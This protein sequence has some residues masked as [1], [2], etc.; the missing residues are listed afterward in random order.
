[1]SK[2]SNPFRG[3]TYD[4]VSDTVSSLMRTT[5]KAQTNTTTYAP[6][7][8]KVRG[9][10]NATSVQVTGPTSMS[11]LNS[12]G[13]SLGN[14]SLA[15]ISANAS[16]A[17]TDS[18]GRTIPSTYLADYETKILDG[19]LRS[20]PNLTIDVNN[21][22]RV[23]NRNIAQINL[24]DDSKSSGITGISNMAPL[25]YIL[26]DNALADFSMNI[27]PGL[28]TREVTADDI[29]KA[30][31]KNAA[32]RK[33]LVQQ[34]Q[35]TTP[36]ST[37]SSKPA[38]TNPQ[39]QIKFNSA[40]G[41]DSESVDD[42][43]DEYEEF[44]SFK[45]G[46]VKLHIPPTHVTITQLRTNHSVPMI[47]AASKPVMNPTNRIVIKVNTI[48]SGNDL[49][50]NH[51]KRIISQYIYCPFNLIRSE[52]LFVKLYDEGHDLL[53]GYLDTNYIPVTMDAFT[54]YTIQ[55]HPNTLG[56]SLQF[57]LFNFAPYY[58]GAVND[59]LDYYKYDPKKVISVEELAKLT[60]EELQKR[61]GT[62]LDTTLN[63][64]DAIHPYNFFIEDI[65][66][67]DDGKFALHDSNVK[68]TKI[69]K[70]KYE[71]KLGN[72]KTT[73]EARE[74]FE[75]LMDSVVDEVA[76]SIS[77]SFHNN[78]AW[79]PIIG[80]STPTA[81]Y[82]GPGETN[83]A[84]NIKTKD[85]STISRILKT[86]KKEDSTGMYDGR[87]LIMSS[88]T[89]FVGAEVA[90]LEACVVSSVEGFP[91]LSD[92]NISFSKEHYIHDARYKN[93][94]A[95]YD[96]YWGLGRLSL[97]AK[98][99][100]NI[101]DAVNSSI[102]AALG[103]NTDI[104]TYMAAMSNGVVSL[105]GLLPAVKERFNEFF[106]ALNDGTEGIA[107]E[108]DVKDKIQLLR[109]G[110]MANTDSPED[111]TVITLLQKYI[112]EVAQDKLT[113]NLK[114][115]QDNIQTFESLLRSDDKIF[116]NDTVT[117]VE[118]AISTLASLKPDGLEIPEGKGKY[119]SRL[120]LHPTAIGVLNL[121]TYSPDYFRDNSGS[122]KITAQQLSAMYDSD[123]KDQVKKFLYKYL[124][125]SRKKF[126]KKR[127]SSGISVDSIERANNR[128]LDISIDKNSTI[129][130]KIDQLKKT[131]AFK[132]KIGVSQL[133]SNG[134]QTKSRFK[135]SF[136][137]QLTGKEIQ[138]S[139]YEAKR[140]GNTSNKDVESYE[141]PYVK[142]MLA[143]P[144]AAHRYFP[145]IDN[146]I[147]YSSFE[148]QTLGDYFTNAK[149]ENLSSYYEMI[150]NEAGNAI[151]PS[152]DTA[153]WKNVYCQAKYGEEG[154]T[155]LKPLIE[156]NENNPL[157]ILNI[158]T[159]PDRRQDL[160]LGKKFANKNKGQTVSNEDLTKEYLNPE[161]MTD[162]QKDPTVT[163][164]SLIRK[165]NAKYDTPYSSIT[166]LTLSDAAFGVNHKLYDSIKGFRE[167]QT[168]YINLP[169]GRDLEDIFDA[170][171]HGKG[172]ILPN[173][174]TWQRKSETPVSSI[175]PSI[176][177]TRKITGTITSTIGMLPLQSELM[178]AG[179]NPMAVI[180]N[181]QNAGKGTINICAA[182]KLTL[183]TNTTGQATTKEPIKAPEQ[184]KSKLDETALK[185]LTGMTYS[186]M[187]NSPEFSSQA[188]AP[189]TTAEVSNDK[190]W[191]GSEISADGHY[192]DVTSSIA[193][194]HFTGVLPTDG[195]EN[196]FPTYKLYIIKSDT[197]DYKYYSLDDYYDFRLVQDVMVIRDKNNPVHLL[198]CRVIVDPK[199]ITLEENLNQ[200]TARGVHEGST[201]M[202]GGDETND[203]DDENTF[204]NN[205]G[206]EEA[207]YGVKP[208]PLRQG[209]RICLKLGY[210]SDPRML[211]TVFMGTITSLNNDSHHI[212]EVEA[213]GDGRELTVPPTMSNENISGTNY[214][215]VITKILRSNPAV[216][217]FGQVYGTFI[218]RFSRKHIA[219]GEMVRNGF[220]SSLLFGGA[221]GLGVTSAMFGAR[222]I[223]RA[224][225]LVAGVGAVTMGYHV[226][227][228]LPAIF[229]EEIWR[230]HVAVYGSYGL[231]SKW[232][233][234]FSEMGACFKGALF[235]NKK[236]SQQAAMHFYNVFKS[237]NNP[238]GDNI[239]AFDIWN[240]LYNSINLDI[241][242]KTTIW[243]VLQNVRRLYP[244]FALDVRPYGNR[245][246]IFLGPLSF[247]YFRTDDPVQAMAPCLTSQSSLNRDKFSDIYREAVKEFGA[248]MNKYGEF[249]SSDFEKG[250]APFIPFQKHHLASSYK[251][252]IHNGIKATPERGWNHITVQ[253]TKSQKDLDSTDNVVTLVANANIDP[254]SLIKKYEIID[255]IGDETVATQYAAGR[256]KEGV[257]RLYGGS[258]ILKGN[259]KIEP[260]DKIYV[261]DKVNN[262][263]GWVQVETVIH[264][265]DMEMGF[266]TH[267]TPNMVCA[268][269]SDAYLS[270][271]Q[272][273]RRLMYQHFASGLITSI[274]T[275]LGMSALGA[276]GVPGIMAFGILA[277]GQLAYSAWVGSTTSDSVQ[278]TSGD[279]NSQFYQDEKVY[280]PA[281][282]KAAIAY[283]KVG[284]AGSYGYFY[285]MLKRYIKSAAKD[286]ETLSTKEAR[287]KLVET[288]TSKWKN[289]SNSVKAWEAVRHNKATVR[290][291]KLIANLIGAKD[292]KELTSM[293]ASEIEAALAKLEKDGVKIGK[294]GKK[295]LDVTKIEAAQATA[296]EYLEKEAALGI[297]KSNKNLGIASIFKPKGGMMQGFGKIL[298]GGGMMYM[299]Y[300]AA[301]LIPLL[302]E[303][304]VM[305]YM[306]KN[307][308]IM[309]YPVWL[310]N[311]LLMQG[312][313]GYKNED[314]VLHMKGVVLDV[315]KSIYDA[316]D[317]AKD[318]FNVNMT[319]IPFDTS[320]ST[321]TQFISDDPR[322]VNDAVDEAIGPIANSV[323]ST[324]MLRR[325]NSNKSLNNIVGSPREILIWIESACSQYGIDPTF[326]AVVLETENGF[327]AKGRSSAG[328]C[329]F[330]QLTSSVLKF[331]TE[332]SAGEIRDW[333]TYSSNYLTKRYSKVNIKAGFSYIKYCSDLADDL[334]NK[335][336][337]PSAT[338][339][340]KRKIKW[341]FTYGVYNGCYNIFRSFLRHKTIST[342]RELSAYTN[343]KTFSASAVNGGGRY[344]DCF[345]IVMNGIDRI[346]Q[347]NAQKAAAEGYKFKSNSALENQQL[348]N[349]TNSLY[350]IGYGS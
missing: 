274:G 228:H 194:D 338:V 51:L 336:V 267:V 67:D 209:M 137:G 4:S 240:N 80:S 198:R 286:W 98:A 182:S 270:R 52:D 9:V 87:Y 176:E 345:G 296:T 233:H 158:M 84:V 8:A 192:M 56:A 332:A 150:R 2:S 100:K 93:R 202:L 128:T 149:L 46:D 7:P 27:S 45:I 287:E 248:S 262:M 195:M 323:A 11:F 302:V 152:I 91:D 181:R 184:T 72:A 59:R 246:T 261:A 33:A 210:H 272:I 258:L 28:S 333:G 179:L 92:I 324:Y 134:D 75:L 161:P 321:N 122:N 20:T 330:M 81:Q 55:G 101:Q 60:P 297:A 177:D 39:K 155:I 130:N 23:G 116:N 26:V 203:T 156:Q 186:Q 65:L 232:G 70:E 159:N 5:S 143:K 193:K 30:A 132:G 243:D 290:S 213:H 157:C 265:F 71:E 113:I 224:F 315:K 222:Q 49:I 78:F 99:N 204:F 288:L 226:T 151:A 231:L 252:I 251:E 328:A 148:S 185:A 308:V 140:N 111:K 307:Q 6:I 175:N 215:E 61:S 187:N 250:V 318:Y 163:N 47:G 300:S 242:N 217:H 154:T 273:A 269:N 298:K 136:R 197:S 90:S 118:A 48:F 207:L 147:Q 3:D 83:I 19:T 301:E 109:A 255:W 120:T 164:M 283:G 230:K 64:E 73:A 103:N 200:V 102:K 69:L 268:I 124:E 34:P 303:S 295:F 63:L 220:T 121:D 131:P 256:L 281:A 76:Q 21:L 285:G 236:A 142:I 97:L 54:L 257:E 216:A 229:T 18:K 41:T 329:G 96:R 105:D 259:P 74:E 325:L 337:N 316:V 339:D 173:T 331:V 189:S 153:A 88:L 62:R 22:G 166:D 16:I 95:E 129:A 36:V 127:V 299:L 171:A 13:Q 114:N 347:E 245:S 180:A 344:D 15:Y 275:F 135:I 350:Q 342:M 160:E 218:E 40:Y 50:N 53:D 32:D 319:G 117:F 244:N 165:S 205:M 123:K 253:Y 349:G 235:N 294:T 322:F 17:Y 144:F 211:D 108:P 206:Q 141:K 168:G 277:L 115:S 174:G 14:Y 225:G 260:Y 145:Q 326:A 320:E 292:L 264:K 311:S 266:T 170:N 312:L 31:I 221:T 172:I 306:T 79:Q 348:F 169:G 234:K 313:E 191:D 291:M 119:I 196:A 223:A 219:I 66:A 271:G 293:E 35:N 279:S 346:E 284:T 138:D 305:K 327:Q 43:G 106:K 310:R 199:Y 44:E 77:V 314:A 68:I 335:Y 254:A 239:Y 178:T 133:S 276:A 112:E 89:S 208:V 289:A 249:K 214:S 212:Y 42:Y 85:Y 282:L 304:T 139:I 24:V 57:S 1:M 104:L 190:A 38:A 263:Y 227:S 12:E 107:P 280:T 317:S 343:G 146:W 341:K 340:E 241:N 167:S 237:G 58:S 201:Q 29:K 86:Y 183:G 94:V 247:N 238:I 126:W 25:N 110:A 309:A 82:I 162:Y 278:G 188:V 37:S 10:S 334:M 125:D